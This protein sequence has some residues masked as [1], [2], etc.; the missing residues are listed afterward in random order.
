MF[1][2][3]PF[4]DQKPVMSVS[5]GDLYKEEQQQNNHSAEP[6]GFLCRYCWHPAAA[7]A[8]SF[9]ALAVIPPWKSQ[10]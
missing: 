6:N 9:P 1:S 2:K 7:A 3:M 4:H 10:L 8:L 5:I